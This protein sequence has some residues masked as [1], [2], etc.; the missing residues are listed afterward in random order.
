LKVQSGASKFNELKNIFTFYSTP[1]DLCKKIDNE[2]I[3]KISNHYLLDKGQTQDS[4]L[5]ENER[6]LG[7]R[8]YYPY[9]K[10]SPPIVLEPAGDVSV[11]GKLKR[12]SSCSRI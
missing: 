7:S 6:V 12:L 10:R 5:N 4:D 11:H 9:T 8:S 1:S 2:L 3:D